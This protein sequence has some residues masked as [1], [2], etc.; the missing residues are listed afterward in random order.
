MG[1]WS[2]LF[3][4]GTL[5]DGKPK[6]SAKAQVRA[7]DYREQPPEHITEL[8]KLFDSAMGKD[9]A[10]NSRDAR[11]NA[12][13]KLVLANE[14]EKGREAWLS[15][16]RDF[17]SELPLALEQVGVC[18]H[19]E[20]DYRSAIENYEA[21]IRLGSDARRLADAIVEARKGMAAFG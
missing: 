5:G 7:S 8:S 4:S 10:N 16:S 13:I 6:W 19:L 12:A 3:G 18:Y 15:I 9:P 21:A 20:K 11:R 2:K 17:P 14:T 1:F